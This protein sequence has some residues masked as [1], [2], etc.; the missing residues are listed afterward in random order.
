MAATAHT[1]QSPCPSLRPACGG[2]RMYTAPWT[3]PPPSPR[4]SARPRG[5]GTAS[6]GKYIQLGREMQL[7]WVVSGA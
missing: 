1:A 2:A 6:Q 7:L 3:A 5:E 4:P